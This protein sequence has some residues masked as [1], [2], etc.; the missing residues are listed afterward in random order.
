MSGVLS[1]VLLILHKGGIK[2]AGHLMAG[3]IVVV[4]VLAVFHG[5]G[6]EEYFHTKM[7]EVLFVPCN[8]QI[9]TS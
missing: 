3:V 7:T 8:A 1:G 6:G 4:V 5:P 2:W 9:C